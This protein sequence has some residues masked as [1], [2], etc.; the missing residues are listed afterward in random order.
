MEEVHPLFLFPAVQEGHGAWVQVLV[1]IG[2]AFKK[3]L[4]TVTPVHA[5]HVP[6]ELKAQPSLHSNAAHAGVAAVQSVIG[7]VELPTVVLG[8]L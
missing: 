2:A 8:P 3:K 4:P 6:D 7:Q 1:S 5:L